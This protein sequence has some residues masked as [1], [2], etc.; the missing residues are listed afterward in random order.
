M[1]VRRWLPTLILIAAHCPAL[2][3][4]LTFTPAKVAF[5]AQSVNSESQ[6]AAVT[7]S[8][9]ADQP[10]QLT[11]IIVSGIDFAATNDCKDELAPGT[12]CS[13]QVRFKPRIQGDRIG[14]IEILASDSPNPHFVPLTG[15]GQ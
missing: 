5:G 11:Q 1:R 12:R 7:L 6:P 14:I 10:I 13:I 3:A 2:A 15:K 9:P 8:N 4:S